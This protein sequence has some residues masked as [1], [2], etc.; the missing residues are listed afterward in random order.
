MNLVLLI[1]GD[2]AAINRIRELLGDRAAF[3]T[4]KDEEEAIGVL[5][6]GPL[7]IAL[8]HAAGANETVLGVIRRIRESDR[9]LTLI[10]IN[11]G[12]RPDGFLARVIDAGAYDLVDLSADPDRI[13]QAV[14]RG[15]ERQKLA[16]ELSVLRY[17]DHEFPSRRQPAAADFSAESKP[18]RE[19]L[20]ACRGAFFYQEALRRLNKAIIQIFDFRQLCGLI[21][22]TVVE[23]FGATKGSLVLLDEETGVYSVR[24]STG[25][26]E[27]LAKSLKFYPE[28]ALVKWFTGKLQMLQWETVVGNLHQRDFVLLKREM[29]MLEA[30]ISVPL[31]SRGRLIGF[32][33][34]NN[35]ING[36]EYSGQELEFLTVIAGYGAVA[37]DNAVL[38]HKINIQRKYTADV[39]ENIT[40][41]V[42]AVNAEGKI[43]TFNRAAASIL[44]TAADEII[45]KDV[46][47]L[48]E[49]IAEMVKVCL[50]EERILHRHEVTLKKDRV[51]LG[52]STSLVKD[53]QGRLAGVIVVF[54]DLSRLKMLEEEMKRLDRLDFWSRL[55]IRMA[56]EIKNPLVPIRTFTQLLPQKYQDPEFRKDFYEVV[57]G[58]VN[59]LNALIEQ[60]ISFAHPRKTEYRYVDVGEILEKTLGVLEEQIRENQIKIERRFEEGLPLI[61][62]DLEQI[63]QVFYH[64]VLNAVQAM[65]N[66]GELTITTRLHKDVV[67]DVFREKGQGCVEIEFRDTGTGIS[68]ENLDKIF[69]PFFTTKIKGAGLG[70]A[71]AKRHVEEHHGRIEVS[72]EENKGSSFKV[73]LPVDIDRKVTRK[74]EEA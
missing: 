12:V 1:S 45:G 65:P 24:A 64:L 8:L 36:M 60:L 70:L 61:A 23:I 11:E 74:E 43:T 18:E 49:E 19:G 32:L 47:I 10:A 9:D 31:L 59:R 66:G 67:S 3:I 52:V 14:E 41:G 34:V 46:G 22:D 73:L 63:S 16:E 5:R 29:E 6:K 51:P 42:M 27:R 54:A 33:S 20:Y 4:V 71:V 40:S 39:L 69:A 28:D 21:V 30:R 13:R 72:S 62:I 48:A 68:P 58:E 15:M 38:Y 2:S 55:T 53:E 17:R 44:G 37:V 57:S 26:N 56:Q 7:G 50:R 35:K 25:L